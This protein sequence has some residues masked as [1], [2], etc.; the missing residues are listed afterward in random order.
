M[1]SKQ[2]FIGT[3]A[4]HTQHMLASHPQEA[5]VLIVADNATGGPSNFHTY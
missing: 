1:G 3:M 5:V 4:G 2:F